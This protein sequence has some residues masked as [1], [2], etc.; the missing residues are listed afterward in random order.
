MHGYAQQKQARNKEN[1]G[2]FAEKDEESKVEVL[3][4]TAKFPSVSVPI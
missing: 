2:P 3:D 1:E 4:H